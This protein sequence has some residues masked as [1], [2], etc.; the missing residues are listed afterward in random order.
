MGSLGRKILVI[1]SLVLIA[2]LSLTARATQADYSFQTVPTEA[3]SSTPGRLSTATQPPARAT[4][5]AQAASTTPQ[6]GSTAANPVETNAATANPLVKPTDAAATIEN[7]GT[8]APSATTDG[9]KLAEATSESTPTGTNPASL[10]GRLKSL[11]FLC[12]GL[13]LLAGIAIIILLAVRRAQ[14][15]STTPPAPPRARKE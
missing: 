14:K 15:N 12:C 6:P 7:L 11:Y 5:T 3:P 10:S 1:V 8:L 4:Q 2:G 9:S 13:G